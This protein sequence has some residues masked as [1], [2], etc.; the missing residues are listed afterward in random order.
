MAENKNTDIIEGQ[1][2]NQP[3]KNT[4]KLL[5]PALVDIIMLALGVC[6]LIWADKV[7][8]GISF[9]IG[10]IFILYATYNF[11]AFYRSEKKASEIAKL[12]TGI[13]MVIAGVFLIFQT[14]FIKELIS[15]VVGIFIIIESMFRLQDALK[16]RSINK[17]LAKLPLILSC[18]SLVCGVLCVLGK[19]LIPDIFLQILG[20]MLIAFSFADISGLLVTRKNIWIIIVL[21]I[22]FMLK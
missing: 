17:G 1:I 10:G 15:F 12:I 2:I 21:A 8:K 6:L 7:V 5:A 4:K 19:I 11:I 13:A 14:D 20:V 16:L 22:S 18:I 3:P 9:V